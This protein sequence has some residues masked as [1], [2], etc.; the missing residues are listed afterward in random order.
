[1]SKN[2][3]IDRNFDLKQIYQINEK[4][5][6]LKNK[7]KKSSLVKNPLEKYLNIGYYLIIPIIIF[8]IIGSWLDK[9][10]KTKPFFVLFFLFFGT[11]SSFYNLF[12]IYKESINN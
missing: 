4:K 11:L 5:V 7:L 8:L 12:K 10:F 2:Y 9:I 3:Q 1:M 6:F